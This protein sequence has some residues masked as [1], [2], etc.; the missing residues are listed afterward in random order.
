VRRLTPPDPHGIAAAA[1][2]L[3]EGR[4]VVFPTETVYGLGARCDDERAVRAIFAAKGR[5]SD[6]PVIVHVAD[7][8]MA[9]A[10]AA[11]WPDDAAR[12]AKAFWPGPLT[13]VVRRDPK[14]AAAVAGGLGTIALRVPDH[15]VA[16]ALLR[17]CGVGVAA[18]SANKSGRPSPTRCADARDDLGDSVDVYLDGGPT[19][20][21]VESTVVDLTGKRPTLLRPGGV[22]RDAVEAIV[23]PLAA[24][25]KS[26]RPLA[27]G[28][29]YRHY[30]PATPLVLLAPAD[31]K[32]AYADAAAQDKAWVVSTEL[33]VDGPNVH[34]VG[35]RDDPEAWARRIFAL[36][37]DLDKEGH[38]AIVVE[39]IPEKGLGAA[40]MDRLRKAAA[41]GA[42]PTSEPTSDQG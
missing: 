38:G 37:R 26:S 14:V 19:R 27:P 33:G 4:L 34:V 10:L 23:G 21:G 42:E 13:L 24:A 11:D 2:A 9:Q 40:V 29:K 39:G 28:M 5:P 7:A 25:P 32:Q 31:L 16:Q 30:A 3:R 35:G 8:R 18:P 41:G 36:L 1:Q 22:P 6:N 17:A 12:L 20:V 15:P